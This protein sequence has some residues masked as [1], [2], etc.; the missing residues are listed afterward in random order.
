[1]IGDSTIDRQRVDN[2]SL[3]AEAGAESGFREIARIKR[4]IAATRKSFNPRLGGIKTEHILILRK[5]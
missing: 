2:T 4:T 3:L 5:S 1:M